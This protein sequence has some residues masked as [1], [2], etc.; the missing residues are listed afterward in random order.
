MNPPPPACRGE[1]RAKWE[2]RIRRIQERRA[3]RIP[4]APAYFIGFM[5]E[6]SSR[7]YFWSPRRSPSQFFFGS[8]GLPRRFQGPSW[9]RRRFERPSE[10]QMSNYAT[11]PHFR[12]SFARKVQPFIGFACFPGLSFSSYFME[13]CKTST[14]GAARLWHR[15][16][17][18][19]LPEASLGGPKR[20]PRRLLSINFSPQGAPAARQVNLFSARRAPKR[21]S[22]PIQGCHMQRPGA[23]ELSQ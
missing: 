16:L 15:R 14:L 5:A 23:Q 4:P 9:Q 8:G 6:I 11:L 21:A 18:K 1:Q 19:T 10:G 2:G 17:P 22:R 20:P 12:P 7:I 3:L 13:K